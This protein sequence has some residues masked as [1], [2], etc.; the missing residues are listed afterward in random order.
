M[1][2][3]IASYNRKYL[4][5]KPEVAQIFSDLEEYKDWVRLQYPQLPFNEEEL[6]NPR[7]A[8]WQRFARNKAR[9]AKQ[10]KTPSN[11]K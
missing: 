3:Q 6:Y 4:R 1:S 10:N 2:V 7:S 8:N 5:M 11:E 9:K